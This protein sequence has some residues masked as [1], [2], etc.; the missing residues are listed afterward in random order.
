MLE[1]TVSNGVYAPALY[2]YFFKYARSSSD[3]EGLHE[4]IIVKHF[5]RKRLLRVSLFP[6]LLPP[7]PFLIHNHHS[8]P[9]LVSACERL[10]HLIAQ[11]CRI[12]KQEST[13]DVESIFDDP[14]KW[15]RFAYHQSIG[16]T[17]SSRLSSAQSASRFSPICAGLENR[18]MGVVIQICLNPN[19]IVLSWYVF[20][21]S[22]IGAPWFPRFFS[23]RRDVC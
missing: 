5:P 6:I 13:K 2:L 19:L 9:L 23:H 17:K 4:T 22:W 1:S 10:L 11:Q 12:G 7:I 18:D 15:R 8:S 3:N 16:R 21:C 14:M 20:P